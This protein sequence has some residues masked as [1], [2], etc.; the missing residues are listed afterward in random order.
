MSQAAYLALIDAVFMAPGVVEWL[1]GLR[2]I[3][4]ESFPEKEPAPAGREATPSEASASG[5]LLNS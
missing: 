5:D 4:E 1:A 3:V 2:R